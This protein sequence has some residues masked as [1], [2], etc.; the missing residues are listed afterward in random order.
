MKASI[1]LCIAMISHDWV[2]EGTKSFKFDTKEINGFILRLGDTWI[3]IINNRLY[4]TQ[5]GQHFSDP[6]CNYLNPPVRENV[7]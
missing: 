3:G 2:P 5:P 7:E 4:S 1:M 6:M